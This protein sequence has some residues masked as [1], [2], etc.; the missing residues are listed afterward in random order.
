MIISAPD[1][2]QKIKCYKEKK[3]REEAGLNTASAA[4]FTI[5]LTT[6]LELLLYTRPYSRSQRYS[7]EKDKIWS[8]NSSGA[9]SQYTEKLL[10][11]RMS[12]KK[13]TLKRKPIKSLERSSR[14][15]TMETNPTRNHEV[16][17]SIPGLA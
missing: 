2:F 17:G 8:L 4:L 13:S 3:G 9:E 1:L 11:N 12:D 16:V 5:Y 7:S 15:S 10:C 14:R 6:I